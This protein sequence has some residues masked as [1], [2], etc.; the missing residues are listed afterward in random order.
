M[1]SERRTRA[2]MLLSL[3]LGAEDVKRGEKLPKASAGEQLVAD[4]A[5][6]RRTANSPRRS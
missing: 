3:A 5:K 6:G 1:A 2:D 4:I